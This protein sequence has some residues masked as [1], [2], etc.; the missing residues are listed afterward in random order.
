[1][2]S[3]CPQNPNFKIFSALIWEL[4][5]PKLIPKVVPIKGTNLGK[6]LQN[7]K[8]LST[9][10]SPHIGKWAT[11]HVDVGPNLFVKPYYECCDS[12]SLLRTE[13]QDGECPMMVIQ[14]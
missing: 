8:V 2:E 12:L 11:F 9:E 4:G 5:H 10:N 13:G 7:Y 14:Q 1:M 6:P 3:A